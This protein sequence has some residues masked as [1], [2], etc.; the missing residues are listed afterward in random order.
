MSRNGSGIYATPVNNWNPATNGNQ[1]TAAEWQALIND[2]VAA[3]TQS[4]SADG[5]TPV[6][7]NI[8]MGTKKLTSLGAGTTTGDSLRFE[9]LF[10]QGAS[11]SIAS[12][13]TTD[14]G[15][16]NSTNIEISG[17]NTIT[18]FGTNYNG[19]RFLRFTGA[20]VLTQSATLNLPGAANITTNAGDTA[21]A[22]PNQGATGW[23]VVIFQKADGSAVTPAPAVRQTV[24]S[25]PV[26]TN[27]FSAFVGATGA[28][29]VTATGTLVATSANGTTNATG[30]IVNPSWTGLSTNGTMYLYLDITASG[31]ITPG[32]TTVQPVYQWGGTYGIASGQF[33]FNIQ[34]MSGQVGNGST[35]AQVNRV[36]V[37]E[38]TVAAAVVTA[39]VWYQL[40]GRFDSQFTTPLPGAL[41]A[42]TK[43]H[44]MG[45][46]PDVFDLVLECISPE[47]GYIAGARLKGSSVFTSDGA[48]LL[49]AVTASRTAVATLT[50]SS[51][52]IATVNQSSG[53][54]ANMTAANWKW[55]MTASRSW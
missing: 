49:M 5:Q 37:G 1:A 45:V 2:L 19:P 3:M 48:R 27:G 26:D 55:K 23:N 30:S 41:T 54:G 6:T 15:A 10:S 38:V 28:T 12:A 9:Q 7:G 53:V 29:T 47:I 35:A 40:M 21:I 25:G 44:N 11:V 24:L 51:G 42:M 46:T 31:V 17:T 20:L 16:Q 32:S 39:I 50:G 18:S 52:A 34:Q 13:A 4:V 22:I 43:T 14:I 33:T 8:A 36:F